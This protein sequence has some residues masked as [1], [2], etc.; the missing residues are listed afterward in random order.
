MEEI[1]I[2]P[3]QIR[4]QVGSEYFR[5]LV[6]RSKKGALIGVPWNNKV[7]DYLFE[8]GLAEDEVNAIMNFSS[9][10]MYIDLSD[11]EEGF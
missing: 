1:K 6:D 10:A 3:S 7:Y 8:S 2:D 9:F 5:N 11:E 4:P